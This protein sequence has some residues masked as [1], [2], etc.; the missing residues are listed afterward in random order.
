ML[1]ITVLHLNLGQNQ[2]VKQILPDKTDG[3]KDVKI[4]VPL[5]YISH[6]WKNLEIHLINSEINLMLTW[7]HKCVL[8]NDTKTATCAMTDLKLYVPVVNLSTQDNAKLLQQLKP[9]F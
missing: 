3:K 6:S 4:M 8:P 9:G 7:S 1:L 2:Q 5:K